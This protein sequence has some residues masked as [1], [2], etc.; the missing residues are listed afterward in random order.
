M[1]CEERR[2]KEE[3]EEDDDMEMCRLSNRAFEWDINKVMHPHP[4]FSKIVELP[5][6]T[7][8]Q[9]QIYTHAS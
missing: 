1:I 6:L 3:E 2:K 5:H 9:T 4:I 8:T 7:H